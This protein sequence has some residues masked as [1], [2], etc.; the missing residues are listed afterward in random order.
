MVENDLRL[1]PMTE[2]G[3]RYREKTRKSVEKYM[4][5]TTPAKYHDLV[6]PEIDVACKVSPSP[7]Q[8]ST[9]TNN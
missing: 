3:A 7:L 5:E 4:R 8:Y 2:A 1:F 6:I 9:R